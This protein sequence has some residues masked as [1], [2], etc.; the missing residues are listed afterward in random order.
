MTDSP[1]ASR[2]SHGTPGDDP[3]PSTGE[4]PVLDD[5]RGPDRKSFRFTLKLLA[6]A[7]VIYYF[8]IPILP[9]FRDAWNDLEE[10]RHRGPLP[11]G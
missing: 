1:A 4:L 8:V 9:N 6:F 11:R 5:D 3:G 7:A 10:C 2:A